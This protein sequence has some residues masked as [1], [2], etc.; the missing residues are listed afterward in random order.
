MSNINLVENT[1][2]SGLSLV[3]IMNLK[4]PKATKEFESVICNLNFTSDLV[5]DTMIDPMMKM[6]SERSLN[7]FK[8]TG[9]IRR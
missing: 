8:I 6:V 4:D 3:D 1:L 2:C 5:K 9:K 7:F